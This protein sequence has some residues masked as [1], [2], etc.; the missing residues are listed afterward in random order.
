MIRREFIALLGEAAATWP[1]PA[2]AQE[3][4]SVRRIGVLMSNTDTDPEALARV[5]ALERGLQKLG[6]SQGRNISV[7]YHWKVTVADSV[8]ASI[9]ELMEFRPDVL[10]AH[11]PATVAALKQA[12]RTT[13]VVFVQASDPV[14]LGLVTNL[15]SSESNVTGFVLFE[16]SLGGKW[17]QLLRDVA[18]GIKQALVIQ[19]QDNP[20]ST[21]F[22]RSIERV[23]STLNV[24]LRTAHVGDFEQMNLAMSELAGSDA[25]VIVLPSPE[26]TAQREQIIGLATLHR[27]PAVYPFKYYA[28]S[29]GLLFYGADNVDQWRQAASYVDRIL[30]GAQPRELPI[31]LPTKFDLVIN[32]K[33]A[34]AIGL[35]IP[36]DVL[37]LA[38][39][40]IE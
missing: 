1:L 18:P 9:R 35:A 36:R 25:G 22:L 4:E 30:R 39:E 15:A 8:R 7:A 40:V 17:L 16:T 28:I 3:G 12:T 13:P 37:L 20:S 10:L 26:A 21:G 24:N 34:S 31:Q 38:D 29:G 14:T 27:I 6:W 23:A 11:T 19:S 5:G 32:L 33:A 2:R